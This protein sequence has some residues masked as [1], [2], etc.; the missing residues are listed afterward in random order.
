MEGKI[1]LQII[2]DYS[3]IDQIDNYLKD[4]IKLKRFEKNKVIYIIHLN[5]DDEISIINSLYKLTYGQIKIQRLNEEIEAAEV[6]TD[7][8]IGLKSA[9]DEN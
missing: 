9:I 2:F 4:L 1:V 5:E 8:P 7:K 3:F 6:G